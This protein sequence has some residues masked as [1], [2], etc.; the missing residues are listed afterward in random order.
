MTDRKTKTGKTPET[1][2]AEEKRRRAAFANPDEAGPDGTLAPTR[3][4]GAKAQRKKP[5]DWDEVDEAL[6]ETFPA[7]D[8]PAQP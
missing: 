5:E 2:E 1:S 6:D 7:S 8:P 4:A 3:N